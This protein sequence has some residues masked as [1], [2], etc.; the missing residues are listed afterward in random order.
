MQAACSGYIK[1]FHVNCYCCIFIECS[2]NR[3]EERTK[4]KNKQNHTRISEFQLFIE[5]YRVNSSSAS[6]LWSYKNQLSLKD[7]TNERTNERNR[8]RNSVER[9]KE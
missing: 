8:E 9:K 1:L 7:D 3:A 4:E 2:I 5:N 6:A